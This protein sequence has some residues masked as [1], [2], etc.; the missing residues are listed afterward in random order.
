MQS[1]N[2][3]R[4]YH[5]HLGSLSSRSIAKL[6]AHWLGVLIFVLS[7][8]GQQAIPIELGKNDIEQ[9][10]IAADLKGR[11]VNFGENVKIFDPSMPISQIQATVDAIATQQVDNE[12]GTQRYTLLFKPGVYGTDTNPLVFQVGYYTEVA[13]LGALPTDVTINGHVDVYNRCLTPDNCTAL[14]NFWRSLSN[15]T[16]NVKGLADCRSSGNFWA[17]SQAAPM[18]R[19]N[20]TGG[21]LTLMDYCTAGPQ[22][23]SG[24]FIADSKTGFIINGSQQQFLVR[25]SN[26]GGWSNGVWNQVFSG[27]AGAPAQSFSTT[28]YD[29][30]PYTTLATSPISREK[31]FLYIDATGRYKVFVPALRR[32]AVGTT[33]GSGSAAGSSIPINQFFIAK[34]SDDIEEIN[35]ALDEGKNLIFTPGIYHLEETIQVKRSD[36]IVLGLGFPTLVPD[37][38]I[39]AMKVGD[40]KGVKLA[41]LM[42]DA[43]SENS[44]SLLQ[45][46]KR[47]AHKSDPTNPTSLHDVFFRIGGATLGKATTSLVLN[48]DNILLDDI[49]VWRADHGN[50]VGWTLNTADTGVIVNGDDVTAYGLFVEHFQKTQVI[51]N[52]ERGRTIMFQNEMPYD[53]PNQAAWMQNGVNGY[54]AYKVADS[55]KTHEAWGLGSYCF[56]N[57]DPTIHA[58]RGFE[59]PVTAGVKLHDLLTVSLGGNGVIDHVVNDTGGPAQGAATIPVNI[60]SFP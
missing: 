41:G 11:N 9:T 16:I 48:S 29:P 21:N 58:T 1:K 19:V 25:D 15:L 45:V 22:F 33:W 32:D 34:P 30:A 31:P 60:V 5:Q 40:V 13:G 52:G 56:F 23:A 4:R 10:G 59:V 37:G 49:W 26:I 6:P 55:V 43:G 14:V 18:R 46:G 54:A 20:I 57:V 3:I 50:G 24:G 17:V 53:P 35:D 28:P 51:W 8:C 7:A 12:M 27:V 42:F 39:V 44:P 47:H 36:T 38:G 2:V